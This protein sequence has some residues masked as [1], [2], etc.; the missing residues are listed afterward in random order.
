MKYLIFTQKPIG[1]P[2]ISPKNYVSPTQ[3]V[4]GWFVDIQFKDICVSY[5]WNNYT[6]SNSITQINATTEI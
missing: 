5:G 1:N 4:E 6:E 3:C 2:K